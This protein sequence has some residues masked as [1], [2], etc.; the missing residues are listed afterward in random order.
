MLAS[1]TTREAARLAFE[2]AGHALVTPDIIKELGESV[3]NKVYSVDNDSK[4]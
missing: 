3:I 4:L 1:M 2:K